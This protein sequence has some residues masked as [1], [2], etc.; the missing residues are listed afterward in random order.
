[1]RPLNKKQIQI[2]TISLI[3]F[4][5]AKN[6][7]AESISKMKIAILPFENKTS[8][9]QGDI[10]QGLSDMLVTEILKLKRYVVFE[11]ERIRDILNEQDFGYSGRVDESTAAKIGK[12]I[13]VD[14]IVF[15]NV[16]QYGIEQRY[17]NIFGESITYLATV[18]I[19]IRIVDV[20]S[21]QVL[22]AE[23]AKGIST[24]DILLGRDENTGQ[25]YPIIGTTEVSNEIYSEAGR[26]AVQDMIT[27]INNLF[28]LHGYIVSRERETALI[29]LGSE[30][31]IQAGDEFIVNQLGEKIIHPV[32]GKVLGASRKTIGTAKI[33]RILDKELSEVLLL[34]GVREIKVGDEIISQPRQIKPLTRVERRSRDG[35]R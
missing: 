33:H 7:S 25:P 4:I 6:L 2:L 18:A 21:G 5:F 9:V 31:G 34:T 17:Q 35:T 22:L 27:K 32:T 28:P 26:Y 29:D 12:L 24:R 30:H 19:D 16:T 10:G 3:T 13:G 23:S 8:Y 15:G 14:A 1:M 20:E 11:R